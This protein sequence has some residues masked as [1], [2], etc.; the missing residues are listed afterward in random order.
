MNKASV[1]SKSVLQL[2]RIIIFNYVNL[3]TRWF[4]G[5]YFQQNAKTTTQLT[6]ADLF[7]SRPTSCSTYSLFKGVKMSLGHRSV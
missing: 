6:T 2:L 5:H 3:L 1:H 4:N 7:V